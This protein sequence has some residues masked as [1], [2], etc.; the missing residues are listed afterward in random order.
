MSQQFGLDN[1][2]LPDL[3]S[4]QKDHKQELSPACV[5]GCPYDLSN[6][7]GRTNDSPSLSCVDQG[8]PHGPGSPRRCCGLALLRAHASVLGQR[9]YLN[10]LDI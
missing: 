2:V 10:V 4:R 7:T 6:I 5:C 9:Q 3:E 8:G 1:L